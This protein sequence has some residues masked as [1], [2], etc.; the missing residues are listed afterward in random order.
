MSDVGWIPWAVA[1]GLVCKS[2]NCDAERAGAI[3]F[4]E[5]R[6][7]RL[8]G[9]GETSLECP[10]ANKVFPEPAPDWQPQFIEQ[11]KWSQGEWLPSVP[12]LKFPDRVISNLHVDDVAFARIISSDALAPTAAAAAKAS[13]KKRAAPQSKSRSLASALKGHYEKWLADLPDGL[14][15]RVKRAIPWWDG[16]GSDLRRR[17][18]RQHDAKQHDPTSAR[19]KSRIFELGFLIAKAATTPEETK[20][21]ERKAAREEL[22]EWQQELD[23]LMGADP[24]ARSDA[25]TLPAAPEPPSKA[26]PKRRVAPQREFDIW[27]RQHVVRCKAEGLSPSVHEDEKAAR[28]HF[29]DRY[30]RDRLR[31]ARRRLAPSNWKATGKRRKTL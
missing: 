15:Q 28:D 26:S 30:D 7:G 27:Y 2:K 29:R 20:P 22:A 24:P 5:L 10:A 14:R 9:A 6:V 19:D 1:L 11:S 12:A 31:S 25:A 18:V 4:D 23:T 3:L 13:S 8:A 16:F 17:F 21:T